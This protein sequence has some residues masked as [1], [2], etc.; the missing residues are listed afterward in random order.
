MSYSRNRN[1]RE[2][3]TKARAADVIDVNRMARRVKRAAWRSWWMP[4]VSVE[5]GKA[6]AKADRRATR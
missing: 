2:R 5:I 1:H 3:A 4:R 6:R